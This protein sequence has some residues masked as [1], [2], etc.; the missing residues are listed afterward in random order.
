MAEKPIG[1]IDKIDHCDLTGVFSII[2]IFIN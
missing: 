1:N 2:N